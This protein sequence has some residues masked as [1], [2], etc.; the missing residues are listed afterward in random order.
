VSVQESHA[1]GFGKS[2]PGQTYPTLF[3]IGKVADVAGFFR[4]DDGGGSWSRIQD[5]AHQFGGG[6]NIAGDPRIH[7][8][9]YVGTHGRGIL[10][11][12]PK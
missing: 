10:Y 9:V 8:R 11:G 12:D 3:L 4:S 5:D 6:L 2:L 1:L 7:G